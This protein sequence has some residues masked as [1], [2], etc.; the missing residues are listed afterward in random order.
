MREKE[1]KKERKKDRKIEILAVLEKKEEGGKVVFW[2]SIQYN[3]TL[4]NGS[5]VCV[6]RYCDANDRICQKDPHKTASS[7]FPLKLRRRSSFVLAGTW[8]AN[9]K[10]QYSASTWQISFPATCSENVILA[11]TET[12]S[13]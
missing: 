9:T 13:L 6:D 10:T 5:K 2:D 8:S 11:A 7:R 1:R 12:R 3:K 4:V